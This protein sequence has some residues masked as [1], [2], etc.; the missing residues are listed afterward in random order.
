MTEDEG[1]MHVHIEY[2]KDSAGLHTARTPQYR[3]LLARGKTQAE[4]ARKLM[5]MIELVESS[6]GRIDTAPSEI[7]YARVA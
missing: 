1:T 5:G 3:G 4:A 7:V 6:H 2:G